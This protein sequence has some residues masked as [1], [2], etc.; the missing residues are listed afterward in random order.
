M[1]KQAPVRPSAQTTDE[2]VED[3]QKRVTKLENKF[4]VAVVVAGIFG[5]SGAFG[6]SQ[7][8]EAQ[9]VL[10][11]LR[12][13]I[14]AVND[15]RDKALGEIREAKI[16]NLKDINEQAKPLVKGAIT[17]EMTAQ[18]GQVKHWT[19]NIYS[20]AA[21]TKVSGVPNSYWL[22]PNRNEDGLVGEL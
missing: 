7:L 19:R 22:D 13:G 1:A 18:I 11:S 12:D 21:L 2:D 5:F 9:K 20:M 4:W 16:Q 8:H 14:K 6:F 10:E 15:A 3:L 17:Q